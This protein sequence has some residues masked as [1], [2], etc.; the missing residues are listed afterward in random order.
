M[1]S[2]SEQ[3]T[4]SGSVQH[5][6]PE[7][8]P[9]NPA[10]TQAVVVTGPAKTIYIGMQNAVD[11]SRTIVGKG[12]IAA[13]TGQT[14]KNLQACLEAAGAR[15]EHLIQWTIYIAQGHSLQAAFEVGQRWWGNR[16]NPPANTVILVP[17]FVPPD[18]LIGIEA[19]AV[20]P[21]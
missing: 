9:R 1:S 20:V 8:L 2:L 13:Q 3:P 19:I 18:F 12:D 7:A 17:A 14:L 11:V 15:P 6:N 10:F 5:L 4:P 16:P 21:L